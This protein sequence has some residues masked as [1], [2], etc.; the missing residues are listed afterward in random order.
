MEIETAE[1]QRAMNLY[2][3][4][5]KKDEAEV[6]NDA[7][8]KAILGTG[9]GLVRNSPAA[10]KDQIQRDL[11]EQGGWKGNDAPMAIRLAAKQLKGTQGDA[12]LRIKSGKRLRKGKEWPKRVGRQAKL[13]VSR[14]KSAIGYF[15]AGWLQAAFDAGFS[16]RSPIK[17]FSGE[18]LGD[19]SRATARHV[20]AEVSNFVDLDHRDGDARRALRRAIVGASKEMVDKAKRKMGKTARKYSGKR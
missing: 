3:R 7:A 11:L 5:T 2:L 19:G 1:L 6:V 14:R 12:S 15:K 18:R 8:R 9:Y 20:V 4:A 10:S 13:I 16:K 17:K